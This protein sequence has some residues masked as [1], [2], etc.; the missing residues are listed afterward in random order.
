M[1]VLKYVII[2]SIVLSLL[3]LNVYAIAAGNDSI[4]NG[5]DLMGTN[6]KRFAY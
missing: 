1:K 6:D 3:S 5:A 4:G 2:F